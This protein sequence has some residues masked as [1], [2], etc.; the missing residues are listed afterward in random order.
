MPR[1]SI[2]VEKFKTGTTVMGY[3]TNVLFLA[4][5]LAA[6]FLF[7]LQAFIPGLGFLIIGA[8]SFYYVFIRLAEYLIDVIPPQFIFHIL[9]WV[10][11][12][13]QLYV[14]N[15]VDP[16]PHLLLNTEEVKRER[17]LRIRT[18]NSIR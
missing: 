18:A 4:L 10:I 9:E 13:D 14:T 12:G 11:V 6:P 8:A 2:P 5:F 15:D 1:E 17:E 7:L 3:G 16:I